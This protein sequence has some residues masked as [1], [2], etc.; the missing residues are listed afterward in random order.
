MT[1]IVAIATTKAP[2]SHSPPDDVDNTS[3]EAKSDADGE[4]WDL[5]DELSDNDEKNANSLESV[6]SNIS[7]VDTS[8]HVDVNQTL[9]VSRLCFC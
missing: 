8:D 7:A 1:L 3:D 5:C 9:A 6:P 4:E 2:S